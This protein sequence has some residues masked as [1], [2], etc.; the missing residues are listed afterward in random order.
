MNK[1]IASIL[2]AVVSVILPAAAQNVSLSTNL[3]DYANLG[4]LNLSASYAVARHWS[5]VADVKYNPFDWKDGN[6]FAKQKLLSAGARIW[7]WHVIFWLVAV[8]QRSV[9]GIQFRGS[10]FC[11]DNG[12]GQ[13]RRFLL[14]R[15]CLDAR[16]TFQ[17][18]HRSRP[19]G[20]C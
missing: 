13:V 16:K 3:L 5:V 19:L 8:K 6:A 17:S 2:V 15:I 1:K 9:A 12:R 10:S 11:K 20:R 7:P 14:C 18:G 4:T